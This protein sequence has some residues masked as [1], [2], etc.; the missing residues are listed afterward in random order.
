MNDQQKKNYNNNDDL[1][2]TL[3][4]LQDNRNSNIHV[5]ELIHTIVGIFRSKYQET[6][7]QLGYRCKPGLLFLFLTVVFWW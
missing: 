6:S 4:C 2:Q 1:S 3:G 7:L 5:P